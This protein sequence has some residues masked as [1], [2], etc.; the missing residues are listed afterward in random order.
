MIQIEIEFQRG[1]I[2]NEKLSRT[3]IRKKEKEEEETN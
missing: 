2:R 1:P 3:H